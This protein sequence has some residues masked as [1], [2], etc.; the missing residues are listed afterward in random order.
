MGQAGG[1]LL[2]GGPPPGAGRRRSCGIQAAPSVVHRSGGSPS[3]PPDPPSSRTP[4]TR[5]DQPPCRG[6]DCRHEVILQARRRQFAQSMEPPPICP[7]RIIWRCQTLRGG[8]SR[9]RAWRTTAPGRGN[10]SGCL[11]NIDRWECPQGEGTSAD[12]EPLSSAPVCGKES[13]GLGGDARDLGR[14]GGG[15]GGRGRHRNR[16]LSLNNS[17]NVYGLTRNR[18]VATHQDGRH[19]S[20]LGYR[21]TW[22]SNCP[23][24]QG[25]RQDHFSTNRPR[26]SSGLHS[27]GDRPPDANADGNIHRNG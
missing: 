16:C 7:R 25:D 14:L 17:R 2:Y 19:A 18:Q 24:T 15:H 13:R 10:I 4:G 9:A 22:D 5:W 26:I 21:S 1:H 27:P 12:G 8:R 11:F 3:S 23:G 6:R 20:G